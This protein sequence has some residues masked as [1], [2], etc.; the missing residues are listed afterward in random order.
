MNL[1]QATIH[2]I[3]RI[4]TIVS[5]M[6]DEWWFQ[7]SSHDS[8]SRL[9]EKELLYVLE[10]EYTIHGVVSYIIA[11]QN[12]EIIIIA[13]DKTQP[14]IWSTMIQHVES[15]CINQWISKIRCWSMDYLN[16]RWFY[17]HMWFQEQY[18][19]THQFFWKDCR[20]FGKILPVITT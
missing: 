15:I 10:W 20:Y 17:E 16:A 3:S 11:E 12:C 2:D 5:V 7:P 4:S 9:L 8:L 6:D 1:R 14:W 19:M 13:S 18:L